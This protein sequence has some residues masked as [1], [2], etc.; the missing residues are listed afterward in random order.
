MLELHYYFYRVLKMLQ[1]AYARRKCLCTA[2]VVSWDISVNKK[3]IKCI[4]IQHSL[5]CQRALIH[6]Q[7]TILKYKY[8]NVTIDGILL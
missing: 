6:S 3:L 4:N 2:P 8:I 5:H 1:I 7:I